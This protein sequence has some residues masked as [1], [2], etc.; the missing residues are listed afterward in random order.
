MKTLGDLTLRPIPAVEPETSL[1]EVT[2]MMEDEPLHAVALVG[3][4][5]YMGLFDEDTL[6]SNLVPPGSDPS[7][8][9]VGP[10]VHPARVV[11]TPEMP[12]EVALAHMT[13]KEVRLIPVVRNRTFVGVL[14]TEDLER[15]VEK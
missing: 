10:Y 15:A 12:V 1:E 3:D 11:G 7:L 5:M 4:S 9:A 6:A 14:T 2:Q 8:L 13:R